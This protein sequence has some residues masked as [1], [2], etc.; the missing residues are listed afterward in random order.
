VSSIYAQTG[1]NQAECNLIRG[2]INEIFSSVT[3]TSEITNI[4]LAMREINSGKRPPYYWQ[5]S[6]NGMM[7]N[8]AGCIDL[9]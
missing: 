7:A 6:W 1:E 9:R 4:P 5:S 3:F 2:K 8:M